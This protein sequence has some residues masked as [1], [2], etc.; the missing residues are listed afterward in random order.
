MLKGEKRSEQD[1]AF[2]Y[3]DELEALTKLKCK[4]IQSTDFIHLNTIN[5]ALKVN[6]ATKYYRLIKEFGSSKASKKD[7]INSIYAQD[8]VEVS[9]SHINYITFF[10]FL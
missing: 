3:L 2:Q 6:L 7:K 10:Y 4:C 8:I 9:T 1:A 5:E